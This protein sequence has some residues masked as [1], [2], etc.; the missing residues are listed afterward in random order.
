MPQSIMLAA[1]TRFQPGHAGNMPCLAC[2]MTARLQG[3]AG[4]RSCSISY[5]AILFSPTFAGVSHYFLSTSTLESN[6]KSY[7]PPQLAFST[8]PSSYDLSY[9]QKDSR[10]DSPPMLQHLL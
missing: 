3:R 5:S 2:N 1:G 8:S 9:C 7:S 6:R 4:D 10:Q